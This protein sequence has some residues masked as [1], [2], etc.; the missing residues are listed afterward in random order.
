MFPPVGGHTVAMGKKNP[1]LEGKDF[2]KEI[3]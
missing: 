3:Y 2:N 1:F